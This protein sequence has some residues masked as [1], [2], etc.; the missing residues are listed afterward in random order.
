MCRRNICAER[1]R[2]ESLHSASVCVCVCVAYR[3]RAPVNGDKPARQ[4]TICK[5]TIRGSCIK[6]TAYM[7]RKR[8]TYTRN[9]VYCLYAASEQCSVLASASVPGAYCLPGFSPALQYP[10]CAANCFEIMNV[11]LSAGGYPFYR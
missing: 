11:N 8:F 1:M 10:A 7:L 2:K 3:V 5:R 9:Y 4:R 6:T